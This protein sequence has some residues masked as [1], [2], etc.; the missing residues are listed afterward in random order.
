M[1]GIKYHV[2]LNTINAVVDCIFIIRGTLSKVNVFTYFCWPSWTMSMW[3][4]KKSLQ[5][6]EICKKIRFGSRRCCAS[7]LPPLYRINRLRR[8][9]LWE[10]NPVTQDLVGVDFEGRDRKGIHRTWNWQDFTPE[11]CIFWS[12]KHRTSHNNFGKLMVAANQI[13]GLQRWAGED[14]GVR[15]LEAGSPNLFWLRLHS[16]LRFKT[17]T[18]GKKLLRLTSILQSQYSMHINFP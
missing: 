11:P 17:E 1:L 12:S 16:S 18:C 7:N 14:S 6:N 3:T 15:H 10:V 4:T 8:M 5:V 2:S 9:R 13:L